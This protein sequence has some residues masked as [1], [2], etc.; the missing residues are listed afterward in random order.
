[1]KH[2]IPLFHISISSRKV[3]EN[4]HMT[5]N[6]R[7][8]RNIQTYQ[9]FLHIISLLPHLR[10]LLRF[11]EEPNIQNNP[12]FYEFFVKMNMRWLRCWRVTSTSFPW[13]VCENP[14]K[15]KVKSHL[16]LLLCGE[17]FCMNLGRTS[18]L[19]LALGRRSS[20]SFLALGCASCNENLL[21]PSSKRSVRE[22][23]RFRPWYINNYS[24][25]G[26]KWS[27]V[28]HKGYMS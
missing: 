17:K 16:G 18:F 5:S 10:W 8:I 15:S 19:A 11:L 6:Q 12:W 27:S 20:K 2:L 28:N 25:T 9:R 23:G 13:K 22:T 24:L 14:W 4:K 1:M 26:D 3:S 7:N 21:E